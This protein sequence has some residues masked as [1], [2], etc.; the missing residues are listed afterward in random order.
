M[1]HAPDTPDKARVVD[2]LRQ[3][4]DAALAALAKMTEDTREEATGTESR[5][6]SQYDTRA[7]EASYL[8]AGQGRR[9]LGLR[10]LAGWL[11]QLDPGAPHT[12]VGPGALVCLSRGA[13]PDWVLMAPEGGHTV[14]VDGV[15][16]RLVSVRSPTG[17][18]LELLEPGDE[19]EIDTPGGAALLR[20]EAVC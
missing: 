10:A 1:A 20:I 12:A 11:S 15:A 7:T 8:A 16:V 18:A 4:V 13:R 14:T 17:E 9:L 6:E 5:A 2:A 3:T 19:A